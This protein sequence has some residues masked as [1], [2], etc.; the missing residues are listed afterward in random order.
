VAM[1]LISLYVGARGLVV[2]FMVEDARHV[3]INFRP[4]AEAGSTYDGHGYDLPDDHTDP[5]VNYRLP[6]DNDKGYTIHLKESDFPDCEKAHASTTVSA[7]DE[8]NV[9]DPTLWSECGDEQEVWES[10]HDPRL[11]S[12]GLFYLSNKKD[13]GSK[14][15]GNYTIKSDYKMW[16]LD[17]NTEIEEAVEGIASMI[18]VFIMAMLMFLVSGIMCCVGCCTMD[19]KIVLECECKPE[20]GLQ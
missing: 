20:Q 19:T 16:V 12:M 9:P 18:G 4:K 14:V 17:V 8:P 3:I 1:L 11:R 10:Q 7:P 2:K 6:E 5:M 15:Y 13:D